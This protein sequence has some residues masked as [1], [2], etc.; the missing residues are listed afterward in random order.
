L[1]EVAILK[2]LDHPDV[3]KLL[4]VWKPLKHLPHHEA[5]CDLLDCNLG[6]GYPEEGEASRLFYQVTCAHEKGITHKDLNS[7]NILADGKLSDLEL[8][9]KFRVRQKQ[10]IFH[11]TLGSRTLPGWSV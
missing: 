5:N 4:H 11:I 2:S 6:D 1:S 3:I 8:S 7:E 9:V 10:D